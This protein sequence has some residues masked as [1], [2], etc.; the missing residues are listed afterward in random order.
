MACEALLLKEGREEGR[1]R[2][3][4]DYR[5]RERRGRKGGRER[6]CES[7]REQ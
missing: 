4:R 5:E 6:E 1:G 7:E 2:F 3:E